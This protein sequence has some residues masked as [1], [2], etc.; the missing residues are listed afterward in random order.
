MRL[1]AVIGASDAAVDAG[2]ISERDFLACSHGFRV[3]PNDL[4]AGQIGEVVAPQLYIASSKP[5]VT[6]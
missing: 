2:A 4:Q 5:Q 6:K 3:H 1:P